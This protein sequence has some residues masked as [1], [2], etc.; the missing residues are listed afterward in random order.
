MNK[1]IIY[2][3]L[4]ILLCISVSS[5][6]ELLGTFKRGEPIELLQI[7]ATCTFVNIT[8]VTSPNS[9]I[10]IEDKEMDKIG[11]KF[12]Y[13]LN[14]QQ[15]LGTY[16]V[17]GVGD[18]EGTN[19]AWCYT[20]EV[21][22]T[23]YKP[24]TAQSIIYFIL[25]AISIS[26]FITVLIIGFN[27]ESNKF[28]IDSFSGKIIRVNFKRYYRLGCWVIAYAMAIWGSHLAYEIANNFLSSNFLSTFFHMIFIILL[29]LATPL[30]IFMFAMFL[31]S[32]VID[33][34]NKKLLIR[35]LQ[36]RR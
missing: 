19:T 14:G 32:I 16:N 29:S 35:N 30:F 25:L 18:L 23:G 17:C 34:K 22:Q 7:C 26:V 12:N 1:I 15:S 10:I 28:D 36:P 27:I 9:S 31:A 21:T 5:S 11:N 2:L 24:T 3:T 6:L 13:T 8:S 33:I 20:F 4:T